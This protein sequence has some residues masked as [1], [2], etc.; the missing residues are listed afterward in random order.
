MRNSRRLPFNPRVEQVLGGDGN[1][2]GC[3]TDEP[4]RLG[5]EHHADNQHRPEGPE[6]E[7][8]RT[9]VKAADEQLMREAEIGVLLLRF[10]SLRCRR[11]KA[12]QELDQA[13]ER[14]EF[15]NLRGAGQPL[16]LDDNSFAG[17]KAMGY[18]L[19]K[20]NGFAPAEVELANEIRRKLERA[21]AKLAKL[22]HQSRT[23]RSRRI[24]P[25]A[26][27]RQA[28]NLAVKKATAEYESTL[29]QLNSKI[30]TLNLTAPA[31]MHQPLLAVDKL[32]Q[33]FR[34]SC[35]LFE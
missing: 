2:A 25:F 3:G 30:L 20:S 31:P 35:P 7:G 23:L 5:A 1:D 17:E 33:D 15:D 18:G 22:R 9:L 16:K 6:Q 28:F 24:P 19:L 12:A 21:E 14:G 29:R 26:S 27:E 32:V 11:R 4:G 8:N 34:T 13:Q 10:Q